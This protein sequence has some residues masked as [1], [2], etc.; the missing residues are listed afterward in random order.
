[1]YRSKN[2]CKQCLPREREIAVHNA[3]IINELKQ[4]GFKRELMRHNVNSEFPG[5]VLWCCNAATD[6]YLELAIGNA[7]WPIG[8]TFTQINSLAFKP[9]P[10]GLH[11]PFRQSTYAHRNNKAPFVK[12]KIFHLKLMKQRK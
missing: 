6:A 4:S 10:R 5:G 9:G 2:F 8:V 3:V 7:P 11:I 1:M 12:L